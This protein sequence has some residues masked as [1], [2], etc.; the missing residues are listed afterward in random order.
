MDLLA[1]IKAE[2]ER[3]IRK[4]GRVPSTG[5]DA[6]ICEQQQ[7]RPIKEEHERAKAATAEAYRNAKG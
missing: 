6:K 5:E 7:E 4:H 1:R 2:R 3:F